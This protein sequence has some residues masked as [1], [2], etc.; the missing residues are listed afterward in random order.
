MVANVLT[1]MAHPVMRPGDGF[2]DFQEQQAHYP[3]VQG[4]GHLRLYKD[5]PFDC[6]KQKQR[7]KK[8]T[9]II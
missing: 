1:E 5:W 9:V 3:Q 8:N 7:Q 6:P 2:K 4:G